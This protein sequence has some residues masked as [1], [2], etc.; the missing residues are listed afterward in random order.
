MGYGF[1][2]A[3]SRSVLDEKWGTTDK[4]SHLVLPG[5]IERRRDM[6]SPE[7]CHIVDLLG[8]K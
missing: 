5:A 1:S 2:K 4:A 7:N 6:I 3:P 8:M